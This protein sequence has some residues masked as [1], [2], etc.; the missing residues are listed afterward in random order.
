MKRSSYWIIQ[1]KRAGAAAAAGV[2]LLLVVLLLLFS[3]EVAQGVAH[4]LTVCLEVVIPSLFCFIAL[5]GLIM[6]TKL[7]SWMF[8]PVAG[9]VSRLYGVKK[10]HAAIVL[11]SMVG[12]YPVGAK[13]ISDAVK[14]NELTQK[15]A[16]RMLCFCVNSGPAFIIGSVGIPVFGSVRAGMMI[17]ASHLIASFVIAQV[18]RKNRD[19]TP[20]CECPLAKQ[21]FPSALVDAVQSAA[22]S[23]TL[24]CCF[25]LVFSAVNTILTQ[26]GA[27]NLLCSS[28]SE[29]IP[30]ELARSA[31]FGVLEVTNGC[32]AL[33]SRFGGTAV[34][35]ASGMT[36]FGG[37]C[38]HMQVKAILRGTG[39]KMGAFVLT[40]LGY[41]MV[42]VAVTAGLLFL[43]PDA[44]QTGAF[45]PGV[46]A[47]V[48]SATIPASIFLLILCVL[49]LLSAKK[50][51]TIKKKDS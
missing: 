35:L 14:D 2:V 20:G 32:L 34:L 12:G 40:R 10:H 29:I 48:S 3:K 22:R 30:P 6:R 15:E 5:S 24:I 47:Q 50:S 49:L 39:V 51:V 9:M 19:T 33:S 27:V 36:A 18:T 17:F 8:K 21:D 4:G 42:S 43:F 11:L 25:V 28:L 45:A 16:R 31:L 1:L 44:V 37:L 26:T 13:L 23:M 7:S 38:V 46:S 41:T